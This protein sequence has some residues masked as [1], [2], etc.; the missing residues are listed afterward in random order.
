MTLTLTYY[1]K[2]PDIASGIAASPCNK[3]PIQIDGIPARE[4]KGGIAADV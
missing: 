2:T 1:R 3:Q 4:F